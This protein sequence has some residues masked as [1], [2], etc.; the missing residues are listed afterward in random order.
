[1]TMPQSGWEN[2]DQHETPDRMVR[3]NQLAAFY[4]QQD[5]QSPLVE[6]ELPTEPDGYALQ[7][8]LDALKIK[9]L[10]IVED[11]LESPDGQ[12]A[13]AGALLDIKRLLS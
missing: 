10:E 12:R 4:A 5:A 2:P 9:L 11:A 3:Q 13:W 7:E 6:V 1:M 8:E